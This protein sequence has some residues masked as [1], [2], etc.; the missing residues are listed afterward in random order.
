MKAG[1]KDSPSMLSTETHVI[2]GTNGGNQ[3]RQYRIKEIYATVSYEIK[4]KMNA[5]A[6]TIQIILTRIDND[7]YST[8]DS[9]PNAMEMWKA[10]ERLKRNAV[11]DIRA[12]RLAHIANP[13]PIVAQQQVYQPQ[14]NPIHYS[15][16]SSTR[17]QAATRNRGKTIANS[18]PPSYDL[19]PEVVDDDDEAFSKEKEIDKLMALILISF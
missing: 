7:I 6:K 18:P 8:I 4:K 10:I 1:S 2:D 9:C 11:N 3:T 14:H 12:E 16:S 5:E 17:S 15:Q 19:E 13:L